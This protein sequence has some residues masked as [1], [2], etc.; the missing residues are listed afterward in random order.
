[1][2]TDTAAY[3]EADTFTSHAAEEH[4]SRMI[5]R[6][7]PLLSLYPDE[8]RE[9]VALAPE[10]AEPLEILGV[11]DVVF[12]CTPRRSYYGRVV[13]IHH[14]ANSVTVRDLWAARPAQEC[15]AEDVKLICK[16]NGIPAGK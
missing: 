10:L 5:L 6:A 16:V 15:A 14:E 4:A 3:I 2:N 7:V 1:M 11:G 9:G 8:P 12:V 13:S